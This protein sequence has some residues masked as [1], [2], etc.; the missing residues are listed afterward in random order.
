MSTCIK[1]LPKS[2]TNYNPNIQNEVVQQVSLQ[3]P[4]Q[5]ATTMQTPSHGQQPQVMNTTTSP[6]NL[7]ALDS[8]ENINNMFDDLQNTNTSVPIRNIPTNSSHMATDQS[9]KPNYVPQQEK[10]VRFVEES[11]FD[12]A[13]EE[14][15]RSLSWIEKFQVPL[16]ITVLGVVLQTKRVNEVIFRFLPSL[17]TKE[18]QIQTSGVLFKAVVGGILYMV[19]QNM[20]DEFV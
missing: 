16:F 11:N 8:N 2:N 18:G 14:T 3:Q 15:P 4:P 20:M 1:E 9:I 12:R 5:G 7:S 10:K 17:F 6:H 19:L 13:I